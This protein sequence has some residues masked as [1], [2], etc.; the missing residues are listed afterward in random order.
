[1]ATSA[2]SGRS[3]TGREIHPPLADSSTGPLRRDAARPRWGGY[4]KVPRLF[5]S[6]TAEHRVERMR[7]YTRNRQHASR[8]INGPD[9][10]ASRT[11]THLPGLRSNRPSRREVLPAL[12]I[13]TAVISFNAIA[14][15]NDEA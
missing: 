1:M 8:S 10:T 3:V 14:V 11:S 7:Q 12:W 15:D 9:R 2:I 4:A 6:S 13:A 5:G